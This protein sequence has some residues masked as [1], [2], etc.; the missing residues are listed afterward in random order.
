MF[1]ERVD[2]APYNYLSNPLE[3]FRDIRDSIE[4]YKEK[5]KRIKKRKTKE[6]IIRLIQIGHYR[7]G[8]DPTGKI[9]RAIRYLKENEGM[10]DELGIGIKKS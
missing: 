10:M 4:A 1:W 9:D 6:G 3:F 2:K 8:T 5:E 7:E